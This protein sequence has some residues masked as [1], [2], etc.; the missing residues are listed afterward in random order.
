MRMAYF[1]NFFGRKTSPSFRIHFK[2]LHIALEL[3]GNQNI[4]VEWTNNVFKAST[5]SGTQSFV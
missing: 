5:I 2:G 4:S 1:F 3:L